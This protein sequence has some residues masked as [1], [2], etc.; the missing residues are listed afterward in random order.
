M[1]LIFFCQLGHSQITVDASQSAEYY[2]KNVLIGS[3]IE[4]TNISHLGM[5]GGMGQFSADPRT[6]GIQSGLVLSTGNVD[7][8]IGPNDSKSSTTEGALPNI[9][10]VASRIKAGDKDLSRLS[11]ARIIDNTI[12]E[13]DFIPF[14]NALEF[15]YV[16]ASEEYLEYVDSRY[17][18]IFG[19]FLTGPGIRK[20]VNLAVLEDR[21][22]IISVN[23]I[24]HK[25]NSEFFRDNSKRIGLF[26]KLFKSKNDLKEITDLHNN[27]QF[28]GLTF[29]LKVHYD[30]I[31]YQKYHIKI[32]IGDAGDEKYDSAIFIEARSFKSVI[33]TSGKYFKELET[34]SDYFPNID[35][36]FGTPSIVEEKVDVLIDEKFEVTNIYF[37]SDSYSIPDSSKLQL[38]GLAGYLQAN[39]DFK[40]VLF[41][42]TDNIGSKN[43]N[44]KLSEKRAK[45]I[46]DYLVSQGVESSR[47]SYYGH[48]F[49]R[50]EESNSTEQG[51]SRNRRVEII[52]EN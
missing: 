27:L 31:P 30:V 25:K 13:F 10:G 17:N 49:E 24:N 50:P 18:D 38:D 36:I 6:I 35:S 32:A 42:Y 34:F 41:G 4:V 37:D 20:K 40:C 12:I 8:I 22:T 15:N 44:Q 21:E 23:S 46:R 45:S 26:K 2:V 7:G 9:K 39:R 3:G 1:I 5:V 48:N 51:R 29:I 43:Y 11:K 47:L 14:N 19:F 52:I 28:D 33:D 16:F